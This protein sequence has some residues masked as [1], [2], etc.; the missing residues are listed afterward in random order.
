MELRR[1]FAYL[2]NSHEK[3]EG[4]WGNGRKAKP[5]RPASAKVHY[6]RLHTFFNFLV[7][8]E[9]IDGHEGAVGLP[10]GGAARVWRASVH[11]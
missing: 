2:G 10:E 9:V 3:P 1:Y 4:R 7:E 6:S 8:E 5:L 11:Q